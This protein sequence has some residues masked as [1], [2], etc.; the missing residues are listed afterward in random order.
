MS[1]DKKEKVIRARNFTGNKETDLLLERIN[2]RLGEINDKL[3]ALIERLDKSLKGTGRDPVTLGSHVKSLGLT[4]AVL[5]AL[6]SV[7][8]DRIDTLVRHT[9]DML[10]LFVEGSRRK[11]KQIEEA[12]EDH[13]FSLQKPE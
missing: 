13:G 2:A 7:G 9:P 12:L 8:I 10:L 1:D 3:E 6:S 5:H 11:V 4:P